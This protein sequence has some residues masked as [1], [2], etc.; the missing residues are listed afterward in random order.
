MDHMCGPINSANIK[1]NINL[2]HSS[3][4]NTNSNEVV[5]N[6]SSEQG[7][8]VFMFFPKRRGHPVH[9]ELMSKPLIHL[10]FSMAV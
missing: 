10:D 6:K 1:M 8:I 2:N 5:F 4:Y 9:F 3:V 7:T